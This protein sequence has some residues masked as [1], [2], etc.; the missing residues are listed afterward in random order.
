M[1]RSQ[2]D[3]DQVG[4]GAGNPRGPGWGMDV[5]LKVGKRCGPDCGK[6][7]T[8][9]WGKLLALGG[10]YS[11]PVTQPQHHLIARVIHRHC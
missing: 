7:M 3:V 4:L 9:P 1:V 2:A 6:V 8:L 11:W 10:E 5:A